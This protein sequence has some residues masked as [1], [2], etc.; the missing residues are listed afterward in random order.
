[1]I[2]LLVTVAIMAVMVGAMSITMNVVKNANV[3]KSSRT[4]NDII[5][6][7]REK[8]MTTDA[9]EW[10]V[11]IDGNSV[12]VVRVL[13]DGTEQTVERKELP[14]K[15]DVYVTED[16][17]A[18]Y[19][20]K[21]NTVEITFKLLNGEVGE[22]RLSDGTVISSG[23]MCSIVSIHKSKTSSVLLYYSTGKHVIE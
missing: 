20:A 12:S 21:D 19:F 3:D 14:S 22:V 18:Q 8:A 23:N 11:R 7:S 4:I 15:V 9:K 13:S 16:N 17:I 5:T 1:M 6:L 2:E 10:V